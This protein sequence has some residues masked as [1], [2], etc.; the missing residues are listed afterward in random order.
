M[1]GAAHPGADD[2]I[3]RAYHAF[4]D[5]DI[6]AALSVMTED[7]TWANGWE[8]G[9]LHGREAIRDYWTRQ[10]REID[11]AVW[12]RA[13]S[14]DGERIVVEADQTVRNL[15]GEVIAEG[16]VRHAYHLRG[17]LIARMDILPEA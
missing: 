6:D 1:A 7:V 4:N 17:R 16:M 2:L 13:F 11:P 15:D 14:D 12:P 10:W 3:R 9:Y 8:G 5:R